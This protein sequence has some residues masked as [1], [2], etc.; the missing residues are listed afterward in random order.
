MLLEDSYMSFFSM[1]LFHEFEKF[2]ISCFLYNAKPRKKGGNSMLI[3][4]LDTNK[5]LY[6]DNITPFLVTNF[7]EI[8][9]FLTKKIL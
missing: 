9:I 3:K 4:R 5:I 2:P 8:T 7:L 6:I 1:I